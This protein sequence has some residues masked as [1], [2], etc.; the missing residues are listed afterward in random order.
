MI[1]ISTSD[2]VSLC[3]CVCLKE[4]LLNFGNVVKVRSQAVINR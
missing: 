3:V 2:D 1:G 4:C